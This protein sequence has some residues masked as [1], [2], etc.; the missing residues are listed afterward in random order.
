[1]KNQKEQIDNEIFIIGVGASAGGLEALQ[2]FLGNFNYPVSNIAIVIAQH[3]SPSY[4]SMLVQLLSRSTRL[5][6]EEITN[7]LVLEQ[8]KVYIT[9]PDSEIS[10]KDNVLYLNKPSMA[11][12]PKP[13]IDV[14]F[15]SLAN[16]QKE[17]AIGIILSGTGSDG[18][19]GIRAIKAVGGFTIAQ[20]PQTAKYD[21]M[22][23]AAIQTEKIDVVLSPDKMAEEIRDFV[24]NPRV[25]LS[26][27]KD[28]ASTGSMTQLFN[29]LSKRTRTDFSNYKISTIYR[30]LEK[31]LAKL[32]IDKID[33]YLKYVENNPRELDQ[34]FQMILIGVTQ[35]FRDPGAFNE[36]EKYIKK[37]IRGKSPKEPVRIWVPGCATGEEPYSIAIMLAKILGNQL[38]NYNIQIFATDI[39]E[40]AVLIAR[41]ATYPHSSISELPR[42]IVRKY[43][44]KKSND[45]YELIKSIRQMVL[46]SKHDVTVN[47]PFLKLDLISCRNLLIYFNLNLQKHVIPVFHYSL[48]PEGILFLGKSET[49]G[50]F[51]DLFTTV[52]GKNKI[53]IRKGG[54]GIHAVRFASFKPQ[55]KTVENVSGVRE[56]SRMTINEMVKETFYNTFEHPY[57]VVNEMMDVQEVYG[58]V[59][60]YLNISEGSMNS[61]ILKLIHRDIQIDLRAMLSKAI[62]ERVIVKGKIKKI[63]F[64]GTTRY[65][66]LVVKPLLYT[67]PDNELSLVIFEQVDVDE[68]LP[69]LSGS[70]QAE[71]NPL[72]AELEHEL[73]ATREHL[74]TYVE[75]LE[76]SNEELQALNEELQ[77]ANEELQSTN[78]EL[79]TS[80]EELQSTNEELQ[81]A[82]A[83]LRTAN[84]TL[85]EKESHLQE[86]EA[87]NHALLS[88]TLQISAL[89]DKDLKLKAFNERFGDFVKKI[90]GKKPENGQNLIS[91]YDDEQTREFLIDVKKVL[92]GQ[93][94][95]KTLSIG[96]E[97]W[98]KC[99]YV[100]VFAK[101][102][103]VNGAVVNM[104]EITHEK[105]ASIEK[106]KTAQQLDLAF[107]GA[108]LAWW[109]WDVKTG[110][111]T[112]GKGKA[113]M[114]GY[115]E[116]EF[117]NSVKEIMKLVHPGDYEKT[118]DAMR[119]HLNGVKEIYETEYRIKCKNGRYKWFQDRGRVT[120]TD[121]NGNPLRL[122]GIVFDIT[123][124]KQLE[125]FKNICLD[126][127]R[128]MF[129]HIKNQKV[130]IT[131]NGNIKYCNPAFQALV[132][133]GSECTGRDIFDFFGKNQKE[134][135]KKITGQLTV[136]AHRKIKARIKTPK[137]GSKQI[138]MTITH[139]IWDD[140]DALSFII[141]EEK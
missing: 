33:E 112:Y 108:S 63:N 135:I 77:S 42:E 56:N 83:Q 11:T 35:F 120:S 133:G 87:N 45:Q 40:K 105:R 44:E 14:F 13:S 114:L 2:E 49:V 109:D 7:G 129:D 113:E 21:G 131:V 71:E 64:F 43:F 78:E 81:I 85:R 73:K 118:M 34:L 26:H 132:E 91:F 100:P 139:N 29:L 99:Y 94:V 117:P 18:A 122:T 57:V 22:P 98:Y 96:D 104:L 4:K 17:N 47:P 6:V 140:E 95:N 119:Q 92:E 68:S 23:L 75:E 54:S 93:T 97:S 53:F 123:G 62:N 27:R 134:K 41:K 103:K 51:A 37:I 9:P 31:R 50:Q 16:D 12:G 127:I 1:M 65:V 86:M 136:D 124:K 39:D 38:G 46:F 130:A 88:N 115:S 30:R 8:G 59:R 126:N 72:I 67:K 19:N 82:Y 55:R 69:R 121:D 74:Q 20:E 76:T 107:T 102:K 66:R 60:M 61:N 110:A 32:K 79:E 106:E 128:L 15:Q 28:D 24:A 5:K 89:I 3:L 36:L 10:L 80:N 70:E 101:S 137:G 84:E 48:H 58:D 125:I 141:E 138:S 25:A 111:V 52:D 90:S 116:K